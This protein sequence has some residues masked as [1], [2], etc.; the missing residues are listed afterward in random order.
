MDEAFLDIEIGEEKLDEKFMEIEETAREFVSCRNA[1]CRKLVASTGP[2]HQL[3]HKVRKHRLRFYKIQNQGNEFI[4]SL[5]GKEGRN[6]KNCETDLVGRVWQLGHHQP[7]SK[8]LQ[9]IDYLNNTTDGL[10]IN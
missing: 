4:D 1:Q 7:K 5:N 8:H 3:F 9:E 6:P 10:W 2:L